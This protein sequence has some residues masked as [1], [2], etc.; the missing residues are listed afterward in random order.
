VHG[1]L[2]TS[3]NAPDATS[4]QPYHAACL[5][6]VVGLVLFCLALSCLALP[7]IALQPCHALPCLPCPVLSTAG[8]SWPRI[9]GAV[10]VG[11]MLPSMCTWLLLYSYVCTCCMYYKYGGPA[12]VPMRYL[13]RHAPWTP[14]ASIGVCR[15][16][17]LTDLLFGPEL[18]GLHL[19]HGYRVLPRAVACRRL[20]GIGFRPSLCMER[21]SGTY[22]GLY[23]S[24]MF[25][26]RGPRAHSPW[27]MA[28]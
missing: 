13:S 18:M 14:W 28:R 2:S 21:E 1:C 6:V 8:G 17:R 7:C 5:P 24:S 16:S 22:T 11:Y 4:S 23:L 12:H 9:S 20:R 10:I 19:L 27:T 26:L 3:S 25:L 15:C